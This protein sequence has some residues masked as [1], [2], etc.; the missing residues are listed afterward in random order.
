VKNQVQTRLEVLS[1]NNNNNRY[2]NG[3]YG[4][5]KFNLFIKLEPRPKVFL[6][7]KNGPTLVKYI[8][9]DPDTI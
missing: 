7:R 9:P 1:N 8:D 3:N 2:L 4:S 6:K 5:F